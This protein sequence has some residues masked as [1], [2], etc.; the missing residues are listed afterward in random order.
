MFIDPIHAFDKS[1][2][3]PAV[4]IVLTMWDYR[5]GSLFSMAKDFSNQHNLNVKKREANAMWRND[6]KIFFHKII[7]K[8]VMITDHGRNEGHIAQC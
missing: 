7:A 5:I 3:R 1:V 6:V 8:G 4:A 2:S